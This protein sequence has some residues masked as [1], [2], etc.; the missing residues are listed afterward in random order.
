[1]ITRLL[2]LKLF[3]IGILPFFTVYAETANALDWSEFRVEVLENFDTPA[4]DPETLKE[5]I[6]PVWLGFLT[7]TDPIW[8]I[9]ISNGVYHFNN[10]KDNLAVKNL[11]IGLTN[12]EGS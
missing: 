7:Q 11:F 9:N 4:D 10:P 8:D 2:C 6:N 3:L 1:L 12:K 5:F